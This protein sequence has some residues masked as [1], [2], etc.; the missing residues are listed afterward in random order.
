[1]AAS[2]GIGIVTAAAASADTETVS[3]GFASSEEP[4]TPDPTPE[5]R[6]IARKAQW[7][8][9]VQQI[10][11]HNPGISAS[12]TTKTVRTPKTT[13]NLTIVKMKGNA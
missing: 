5:V 4:P 13:I 12:T 8:R 11:I 2:L 7:N 1:M 9:A 6:T 3:G 10:K